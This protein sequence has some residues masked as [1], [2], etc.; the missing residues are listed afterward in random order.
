MAEPRELR[1]TRPGRRRRPN[2]TTA[3]RAP[4]LDPFSFPD[5]IGSG[6][7]VFHPRGGLV[8]KI[9]EDHS[10]Q[11]H[12][13]AGYEFVNTPHI[14]KAELFDISGHLGFYADLMYPLMHV[15]EERHLTAA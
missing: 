8:R 3:S 11:R 12:L 14:S 5:E 10:R 2:E 13:E 7:A 1:A 9:M 4:S 15:D 6:L